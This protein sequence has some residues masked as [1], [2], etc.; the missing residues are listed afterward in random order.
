MLGREL[1]NAR[2]AAGL[3]QDEV[4]FRA[5]VNRS[6]MSYLEHDKYSPTV[7]MLL[8]VC[9]ALGVSASHLIA[10][11]ERRRRRT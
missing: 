2:K 11:V 5:G 6:Y 1:Q 4:A 10:R 8:R 3:T 7:E 9:D